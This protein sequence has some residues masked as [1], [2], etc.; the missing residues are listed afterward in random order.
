MPPAAAGLRALSRLNSLRPPKFSAATGPPAPPWLDRASLKKARYVRCA[1]GRG[2]DVANVRA[3]RRRYG[4]TGLLATGVALHGLWITARGFSTAPRPSLTTLRR[5]F[6]VR[7]SSRLFPSPAGCLF[8]LLPS[9]TCPC[10]QESRVE[11]QS[12]RGGSDGIGQGN[13]ERR[14]AR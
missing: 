5:R 8:L 13:G 4:R 11:R 7:C 9:S 6:R 1:T 10:H 3:G 2:F 12:E 14:L